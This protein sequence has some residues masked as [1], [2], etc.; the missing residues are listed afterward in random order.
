MIDENGNIIESNEEQRQQ[1]IACIQQ[2]IEEYC[3]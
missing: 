2:E 1:K 3:N